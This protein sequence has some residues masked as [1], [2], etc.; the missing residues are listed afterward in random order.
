MKKIFLIICIS[1]IQISFL[2]LNI[3]AQQNTNQKPEGAVEYASGSGK[4]ERKGMSSVIK[5]TFS[6]IDVSSI[7]AGS[8]YVEFK[9]TG[10]CSGFLI[11]S[12]KPVDDPKSSLE[13]AQRGS[14]GVVPFDFVKNGISHK[15]KQSQ[16]YIYARV[17]EGIPVYYEGDCTGDYQYTIYFLEAN[18]TC[19]ELRENLAAPSKDDPLYADWKKSGNTYMY[20]QATASQLAS[21]QFEYIIYINGI[22][23]YYADAQR[24][25]EEL[26]RLTNTPVMLIYNH[27]SYKS[28]INATATHFNEIPTIDVV[29]ATLMAPQKVDWIKE[30]ALINPKVARHLANS[31]EQSSKKGWK[32]SVITYSQGAAI[33]RAAMK[34]FS[35]QFNSKNVRILL[36]GGAA[37][38]SEVIGGGSVSGFAHKGDGISQFFGDTVKEEKGRNFFDLISVQHTN[39]FKGL[40]NAKGEGSPE[41]IKLIKKWSQGEDFRFQ[42]LENVP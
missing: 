41:A 42:L 8:F 17:Q 15:F 5:P 1:I 7:K 14:V 13:I 4:F 40:S 22:E 32:V 29:M 26:S 18:S 16:I 33:A 9:S 30:N 36:I 34:C 28:A 25:T 37:K 12:A 23:T 19:T 31:I 39:Y 2:A 24:Q 11:A 20:P 38:T 35:P 21:N 6:S 10:K 3:T 27:S